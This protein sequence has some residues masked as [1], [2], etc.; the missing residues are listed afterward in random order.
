MADSSPDKHSAPRRWW[1][2]TALQISGALLGVVVTSFMAHYLSIRGK[3]ATV[4]VAEGG[5]ASQARKP[6]ESHPKRPLVVLV[7]SSS[8]S[9]VLDRMYASAQSKGQG[10]FEVDVRPSMGVDVWGTNA[11]EIAKRKPKLVVLHLHTL[12]AAVQAANPASSVPK[13]DA[14]AAEELILGLASVVQFSSE[15][16]YLFY[17]SSFSSNG[18][19]MENESFRRALTRAKERGGDAA[20]LA[21]LQTNA[22]AYVLPNNPG[23]DALRTLSEQVNKRVTAL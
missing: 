16:R 11:G 13:Q 12:R 14:Y 5:T 9:S 3:E 17:S 21:K 18:P 7:D 23:I 22:E 2:P 15:T 8:R 6:Q 4:E 1:H 10:V 19:A 20:N